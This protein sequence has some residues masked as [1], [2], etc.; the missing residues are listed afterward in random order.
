MSQTILSLC[1]TL[2]LKDVMFQLRTI[3]FTVL[4][5]TILFNREIRVGRQGQLPPRKIDS[6]PKTNPSPNSNLSRGEFSPEAIC[7]F[8]PNPNTNSNLDP[9][10]NP[11]QGIIFLCE[12]LSYPNPN[13]NWRA[14]FLGGH[15]SGYLIKLQ[16]ELQYIKIFHLVHYKIR[17]I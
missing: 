6:Q 3:R 8:P 7:W 15:L 9:S 2:I 4:K 17:K 11:N 12:K 13:L 1:R 16:T 5:Q 10:P 14:I